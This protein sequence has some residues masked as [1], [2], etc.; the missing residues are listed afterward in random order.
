MREGDSSETLSKGEVRTHELRALSLLILVSVLTPF[1]MGK[2]TNVLALTGLGILIPIWMSLPFEKV[3]DHTLWNWFTVLSFT[4]FLL[5]RFLEMSWFHSITILILFSLVFEIYGEKRKTAHIR[6]ISLLSFF[7]LIAQFR[8]DQGISIY[9]GILLF[10]FTMGLVLMRFRQ[11]RLAE[12]L[13]REWLSWRKTGF[14][15]SILFAFMLPFAMVLFWI[16]PRS[17]GSSLQGFSFRNGHFISAFSDQVSLNDIGTITTSHRHVFDLIPKK[18]AKV[19]DSYITGRILD[20]FQSG[21]W[22]STTNRNRRMLSPDPDGFITIEKQGEALFEYEISIRPLKGNPVFFFPE[23]KSIE[24]SD[25]ILAEVG[26]KHFTHP[27]GFPQLLH[28]NLY[29][30]D[31]RYD[32]PLSKSDFD[33]YTSMVEDADFLT[34]KAHLVFGTHFADTDAQNKI[35]ILSSYFR[36][37]FLYTLNINNYGERDPLRYFLEK[38]RK[39][40]C[41]LFASSATMLLRASGLPARLVTGFFLPEMIGNEFYH[42]T[43]AS[44]HAWVEVWNGANWQTFD[45]TGVVSLAEPSWFEQQTAVLNRSW[46]DFIM[47]W[48]FA[49]QKEAFQTI[50]STLRRIQISKT[51]LFWLAGMFLLFSA[52]RFR[53]FLFFSKQTLLIKFEKTVFGRFPG[54]RAHIPWEFYLEGISAEPRIKSLL[55]Q[56]MNR[57]FLFAYGNLSGQEQ[58]K[59]KNELKQQLN[60]IGKTLKK[61]E[62]FRNSQA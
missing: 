15:M 23:V 51:R 59:L 37:N 3:R 34:Q 39:G 5:S 24:I 12:S 56:W 33:R 57:Y 16:I 30:S 32:Q 6:I 35:D 40:H 8:F 38:S 36:A 53:A 22:T 50:R 17:A 25:P 48:D 18:G 1:M 31:Q 42:V 44:A 55:T 13:G 41:E 29:C 46:E 10:F 61:M 47:M 7:M 62:P 43:E 11:I 21:F 9:F 19:P 27:S 49:A 14:P 58:K 26:K 2:M 60:S 20:H 54:K 4:L 28:Y 45:P 52:W